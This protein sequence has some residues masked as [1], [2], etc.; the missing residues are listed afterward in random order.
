MVHRV[1]FVVLRASDY[2]PIA[3]GSACISATASAYT[4]SVRSAVTSQPN[5]EA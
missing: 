1:S 3:V 5:R 2:C 4:L